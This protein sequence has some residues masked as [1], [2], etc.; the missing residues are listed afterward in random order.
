M[1]GISVEIT[2]AG[3][4]GPRVRVN[5]QSW[6]SQRP[7]IAGQEPVRSPLFFDVSVEGLTRGKATVYITHDNVTVNHKLH[8][9]DDKQKKWSPHTA[10]TQ[11]SK[12]TISAKFDVADLHGTPIVIGTT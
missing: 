8:H 12:K 1:E 2:D 11:V 10:D 6:G 3:T 4:I 7:P 9:W 5:T